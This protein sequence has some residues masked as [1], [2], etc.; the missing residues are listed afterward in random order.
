MSS[1][2]T[3]MQLTNELIRSLHSC[4]DKIFVAAVL[5]CIQDGVEFTEDEIREAE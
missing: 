5:E 2:K 4:A 3:I 1:K